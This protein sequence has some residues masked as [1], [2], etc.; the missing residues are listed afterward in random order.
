MNKEHMINQNIETHKE[1]S[2]PIIRNT[3]VI[4][5]LA[6]LIVGLGLVMGII[7]YSYEWLAS[8]QKL[9]NLIS[10]VKTEGQT[11]ISWIFENQAN[12]FEFSHVISL[13]FIAWAVAIIIKTIIAFITLIIT[14]GKTI[15]NLSRNFE[16]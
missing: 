3:L 9:S 1:K 15:L 11:A 16:Q 10:W 13:I 8:D 6:F 14:S 7:Y 4:I 5:G 2:L 12:G